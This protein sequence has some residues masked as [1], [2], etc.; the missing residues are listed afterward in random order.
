MEMLRQLRDHLKRREETGDR[1]NEMVQHWFSKVEIVETNTFELVARG[2]QELEN[3]CLG[4]CCPRNCWSR[5]KIGRKIQSTLAEAAAIYD[6][7]EQLLATPM[8]TILGK[9]RSYIGKDEVGRIGIYGKGGIGKTT[10]MNEI[11]SNLLSEHQF[12]YIIWVVVSQDP[13]LEKIQG[14]VGK[15]VGFLEERWKGKNQED[16]AKEISD[17]LSHKRFLFLLDD[18]WKPVDLT[19]VGVPLPDRENGSKIIFTTRSEEVCNQMGAEEKVKVVRLTEK[20]SLELFQ[21][22]VGED[23]LRIDQQIRKLAETIAKMCDG[24]PL[25]LITVGQAM[26]SKKTLQEWNHSFEVLS[27]SVSE[28]SGAKDPFFALLKFSYDSLPSDAIK[29]CFLYCSLFPEDFSISKF[30]LIDYWIGEGF[31]DEFNDPSGARNEGKKV[32]RT[33][34]R[35]LL[36][37]D[38]GEDVKMHDLIREVGLWIACECGKLQDKYLVEAGANLIEAPEI[39][40]WER[41]RRMSLMSNRIQSLTKAPRCNDLS[42]LFLG[43]NHLKIIGNAFFQFMPSLKVLD[44]SGNRELTELPSGILKIFSLQYLNLSSTG[45]RQL[46]VELRNLVKLKCLNLEYTYELQTI[47]TRVI[48]GFLKLKVLRMIHCASSDRTVG[49]GIQTGGHQSFVMVLQ[50][51]EHLNEL[52]LSIT[53]EYSL[54]VFRSWDKFQTCTLAL[55]LHH[56]KHSRSYIDISFL[57]GMKCLAD[58]EFIN[59]INLKELR[60]EESLIMRGGSFNS[61]RKVSLVSCSKLEDLTWLTLAPNLE[62]L[63]VSRCFNMEE[64]ICKGKLVE[65]NFN[66]FGKLE[67]LRLVSLPKLKSIYPIALPFQCLKEIVV[68]ECPKLKKLPLNSNSAKEH[69]IVIQGW[70]GW[71]KNLEWENETTRNTFLLSF[72]SCMY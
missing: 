32:I 54:E 39:G 60:I 20:K 47:P 8:E 12:D 51:L 56:F 24:L 48:S 22:N 3:N 2:S 45:I 33:L 67:I 16:R 14:D 13:N 4:S 55:S 44:L 19:E 62:F 34:V 29:S 25:A 42:T 31:L 27:K 49:D 64:I 38:D 17:I 63:M 11:S 69:R 68:D 72:K 46:P 40:R 21:Q 53:S 52:T 36:L 59:C 71:W 5:H 26:A 41:A 7:G 1:L 57:D 70:E 23:T 37:Q 50:Q 35:A 58:L 28:I 65:G 9:L 66:S 10:V 30:N 61:L 18:I 6:E 15:E 43:N